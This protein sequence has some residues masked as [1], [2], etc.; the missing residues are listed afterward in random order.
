LRITNQ[1]LQVC[2]HMN[3]CQ[4]IGIYTYMC[5]YVHVHIYVY[6]HIHV[7]IHTCKY[8]SVSLYGS[9]LPIENCWAIALCV[10]T[11]PYIYIYVYI[12]MHVY[13]HLYTSLSLFRYSSNLTIDN[14]LPKYSFL[15]NRSIHVYICIRV[16]TYIHVYA[17]MYIWV[18]A[19]LLRCAYVTW[20]SS[21][22]LNNTHTPLPDDY[23]VEKWGA[24]VEYHFQEI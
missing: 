2:I 4:Y 6:I 12:R 23:R 11:H 24:G 15:P 13:T 20:E 3:I 8:L 19:H 9:E 14:G 17:Y 1:L 16:H 22:M 7:Y 18:G 21:Y 10:Y 5:I